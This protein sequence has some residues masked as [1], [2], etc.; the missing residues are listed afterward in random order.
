MHLG[1]YA[2]VTDLGMP[3]EDQ[4]WREVSAQLSKQRRRYAKL[5]SAHCLAQRA[6]PWQG[7][8][9]TTHAH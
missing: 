2:R 1:S 5:R 3:D 8:L 7:L 6:F 4:G 9:Q